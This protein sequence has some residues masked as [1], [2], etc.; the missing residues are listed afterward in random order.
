MPSI[1]LADIP[2]LQNY[3]HKN[4]CIYNLYHNQGL[5]L[6]VLVHCE[7]VKAQIRSPYCFTADEAAPIA[8]V[9]ALLFGDEAR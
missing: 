6:I 4:G 5:S 1:S 2:D 3:L 8:V 9:A 7:Y